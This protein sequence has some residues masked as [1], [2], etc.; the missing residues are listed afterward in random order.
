MNIPLGD[1]NFVKWIDGGTTYDLN[2]LVLNGTTIWTKNIQF[3]GTSTYDPTDKVVEYVISGDRVG[4]FT[5]W[6]YQAVRQGD[7]SDTGEV[8]VTGGALL[9]ASG[10]LGVDQDGT[11]NVTYKGYIDND[12]MGTTTSTV[13]VATPFIEITSVTDLITRNNVVL[14]EDGDYLITEEGDF[15]L[16]EEDDGSTSTPNPTIAGRLNDIPDGTVANG[17]VVLVGPFASINATTYT[18]SG[19]GWDVTGFN[20]GVNRVEFRDNNGT[21]QARYTGPSLNPEWYNI[22]FSQRAGSGSNSGY[23]VVM[24]SLY[25]PDH[26]AAWYGSTAINNAISG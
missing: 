6:S 2:F 3:T 23:T 18:K 15:V 16:V 1:T 11:W 21:T 4:E 22:S 12:V 26:H 25:M 14:H 8:F 20:T 19:S 10:V 24:E 9:T 5:K 17:E 13:V 7:G